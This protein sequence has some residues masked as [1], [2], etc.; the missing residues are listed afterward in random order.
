[1]TARAHAMPFGTE[2]LAGGGAR[3]RLWAPNATRVDLCLDD[4]PAQAMAAL[5]D[6]WFEA[7]A[8]AAPGRR[9][10]Y[11]IDG[12]TRV[13]DPASRCNPD[14]VHG[15]SELVDPAAYLWRDDGWRGRPWTEAV[16]YE[17]HVG[18]FTPAGSFRA[19]IDR[20]DHLAALG[21][22]AI[23]LMPVAACP[24]QRGWG[25][26]GVLPFAPA[27]AYGR[28]DDL[29]ALVEAAHD[30]GLMVLLDVVYNHFGPEGNY[31]YRYARAFFSERHRT[32]WGAAI[33]FDGETSRTVRDYFIHNALYWLAE[34]HLDGLRLD[35]AHAIPDDSTPH[36]LSELAGAV[37]A[38][39]GR[40]RPIHLVLEND[41]NQA[42]HLAHG[43]AAQW[44]DDLHHALHC[45]LTGEADGYYADYAGSPLGHLGRALAEGFAWQGEASP[46]RHGTPRGEP[47]GDLPPTAFV[48]FLQNH[49]QVGNRALGER[50]TRLAR[51]EALRAATAVLLLAP[52]VPLLFM[53]QEFAAATPFLYFCAFEPR[54]CR[55]VAEGRRDE[56]ARFAA[57]VDPAPTAL[58]DPC[59]AATFAACRLDWASLDRPEARAWLAFHRDLLAVRRHEIVPRLADARGDGYRR[60]GDGG[61][62]VAWRLADGSRLHLIANLADRPLAG[63][64]LPAGRTLYRLP[65]TLAPDAAALPAW[66]V[67][68]R[69]EAAP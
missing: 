56:F 2:V 43:Y 33:N 17:L 39:P 32:P 21:V 34:Y 20:L 1:M 5:P 63:F 66:A 40:E 50:L 37:A 44:N 28:P 48:A 46:Y 64:D 68:W 29:K 30:R 65:A 51:P 27:A 13:P 58:P 57:F 3:F 15:A 41:A 55:A 59:A 8:A 4:A 61:L 67:L 47:S 16:V 24:G 22:T 62:A 38:G 10:R 25:Y 35:A 31:L 11:R 69:L 54:L 9:Y 42:R 23:E 12:D 60:L 36:F 19:A 52:Q 53:G 18:C 7:T 45:L 14:G 26:D 49:D 6:G